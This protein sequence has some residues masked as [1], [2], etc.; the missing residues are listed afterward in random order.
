MRAECPSS[1]WA[2]CK[3]DSWGQE[4]HHFSE[5]K[6]W[7]TLTGA[8]FSPR[9]PSPTSPPHFCLLRGSIISQRRKKSPGFSPTGEIRWDLHITCTYLLSNGLRFLK[10]EN[11][12]RKVKLRACYGYYNG[13]WRQKQRAL[14]ISRL[15]QQW[16]QWNCC[17]TSLTAQVG[18]SESDT[19]PQHLPFW[20]G[21]LY[22]EDL[23]NWV[24]LTKLSR[25]DLAL[26]CP[27]WF[28]GISFS[29]GADHTFFTHQN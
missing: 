12:K 1:C 21:F 4:R 23:S 6:L 11:T 17:L 13:Q 29:K 7:N 15:F 19:H 16:D 27:V 18:V 20:V 9:F 8:L 14:K 25:G 5:E 24:L 22:A 28:P 10:L 26:G 3:T 2:W